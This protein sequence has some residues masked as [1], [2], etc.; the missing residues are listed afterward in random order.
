V[1]TLRHILLAPLV[2]LLLTLA[3]VVMLPRAGA[4][5]LAFPAAQTLSVNSPADVPDAV[6]GDGACETAP[7]N[8]VCTLRAAIQEANATGGA[9]TI[10]LPAGPYALLR[11]GVDNTALN[12]DLDIS[13]TVT[14]QGAGQALALI[15][16]NGAVTGDRV[17]HI[18]SGA[19]VTLS[20]ITLQGGV[21][22][23]GGGLSN[24]G[25]L[26]LIDS[27]IVSNTATGDGG[28]IAH[29]GTSMTIQDSS[30]I[31]NTSGPGAGG[32]FN[33]GPSATIR[34]SAISG[35]TSSYGAGILN[36]G[37]ASLVLDGVRMQGN[38]ATLTGGSLYNGAIVTATN[39]LLDGN[40]AGTDGG[41][42][43]MAGG[44]VWLSNSTLSGN[45]ANQF[46]GGLYAG[47]G[48][49]YLYNVT[50]AFN[51]ADDDN[52]DDS[53]GGG[54]SQTGAPVFLQNTILANNVHPTSLPSR[55]FVAD[56][57]KGALTSAGFNL[58]RDTTGCT[59]WGTATGN[60]IGL[61]PLLAPLQDNGGPTWTH[62]LNFG[63]PAID[64]GNPGGCTGPLGAILTTDQRGRPRPAD[65]NHD[66]VARCDIGAFEAQLLLYLPLIVR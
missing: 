63:S 7:N 21:A 53:D 11:A 51:V 1:K 36:S 50:L 13:R 42:I 48:A 25:A 22:T 18:L 14:L 34:R 62:A 41:G 6:P 33:D 3:I 24:V 20:G 47:L 31:S 39:V 16:G 57:C 30:I 64:A 28:G 5:A 23:Y 19:V 54:I 44:S 15:D 56:D 10:L 46:G 58:I 66:G 40:T 35:N 38:K 43:Y 2:A 65:G 60:I 12:G 45:R 37:G 29:F 26:T 55:G 52:N 59:I 32:L 61:D 8:N 9:H 17:I 27:T 49:V 4:S